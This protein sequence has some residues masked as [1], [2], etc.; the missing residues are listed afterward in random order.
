M[1]EAL[2]QPKASIQL[3]INRGRLQFGP[4]R[5]DV[6]NALIFLSSNAH[7][8]VFPLGNGPGGWNWQIAWDVWAQPQPPRGRTDARGHTDIGVYSEHGMHTG[9]TLANICRGQAF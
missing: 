2:K 4:F 3:M 9:P 1:R 8:K 7:T 6:Q 5:N